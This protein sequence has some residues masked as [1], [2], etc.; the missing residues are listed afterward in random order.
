MLHLDA[1]DIHNNGGATAPDNGDDVLLWRDTS[2]NNNHGTALVASAPTYSLAGGNGRPVI[3][4]TPE[5]GADQ[6][7]IPDSS[8]LGR[9][10]QRLYRIFCD[11]GW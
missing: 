10:Q 9:W 1:S 2:G 11:G 4:F 3:A 5:G 6:I 8:S 7:V